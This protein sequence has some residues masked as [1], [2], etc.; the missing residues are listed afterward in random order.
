VTPFR[1]VHL[2]FALEVRGRGDRPKSR[3]YRGLGPVVI[4][5]IRRDDAEIVCRIVLRPGEE[6]EV[7]RPPSGRRLYW[8]LQYTGPF[9]QLVE[10]NGL[11]L[12]EQGHLAP[13]GGP[14]P[15]N[16]PPARKADDLALANVQR[17]AV[18]LLFVDDVLHA[19]AG[20]P[21]LVSTKGHF[22]GTTLVASAA[23][24]RHPDFQPED[25]AI[26]PGGYH[27]RQVRKDLAHGCFLTPSASISLC[28]YPRVEG[29]APGPDYAVDI[30]VDEVFKK[31][32][33]LLG[34]QPPSETWEV[35]RVYELF[36]EAKDTDLPDLTL[37]RLRALRARLRFISAFGPTAERLTLEPDLLQSCLSRA[38][39]SGIE[40][41]DENEDLRPQILSP[42]D[43][44]ALASLL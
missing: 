8:P 4:P 17:K 26:Q 5:S 25:L 34:S 1:T 33:S 20:I 37:A 27:T 42:E 39:L 36:R 13:F 10:P 18:E 21:V 16:L 9:N 11:Q 24:H 2:P 38:E 3:Y 32:C 29:L 15:A 43:E 23:A 6:V 41:P 35:K 44:D 40:L 30:P 28:E 31:M 19:P 14:A 7:L 12:L 22:K